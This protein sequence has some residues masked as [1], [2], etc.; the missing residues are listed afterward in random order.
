MKNS[1]WLPIGIVIGIAVLFLGVQIW[2]DMRNSGTLETDNLNNSQNSMDANTNVNVG[3]GLVI[4]DTLIGTGAEAVPGKVI[5]VHYTGKL[6]D[7]T[8]FDSSV[9]RNPITITLGAGQVIQ[10]WDVGLQGMK[11]GGKR[12]LTIPPSM[13]YGAQDHGPIPGNSTLIFDVE[14]VSVK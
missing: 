4:D 7:G 12:T 5:A 2:I 9:G 11:V 10:G 6:T 1:M 3:G 8:V 13:G 14:L